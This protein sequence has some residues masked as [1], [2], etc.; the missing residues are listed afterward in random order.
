MPWVSIPST[1]EV[2]STIRCYLRTSVKVMCNDKIL[3]DT[4]GEYLWRGETKYYK[5]LEFRTMNMGHRHR[6]AGK[7]PVIDPFGSSKFHDWSFPRKFYAIVGALNEE[8]LAM[9]RVTCHGGLCQCRHNR[10]HRYTLR[11]TVCRTI[12]GVIKTIKLRFNETLW[13]RKHK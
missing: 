7:I 6:A 2:K 4:F 9:R 3:N 11:T 5:I 12:G 10:R 8:C 1:Y 13:R